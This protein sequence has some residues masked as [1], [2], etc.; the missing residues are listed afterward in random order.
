M[1]PRRSVCLDVL[2][3]ICLGD[4]RI[5]TRRSKLIHVVVD[6]LVLPLVGVLNDFL[7]PLHRGFQVIVLAVREAVAQGPTLGLE[8]F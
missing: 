1:R 3:R 6:D 8:P 5:D 4:N 7:Q 2:V